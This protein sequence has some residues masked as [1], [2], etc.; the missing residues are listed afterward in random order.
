[1][2][3]KKMLLAGDTGGGPA[4]QGTVSVDPPSIAKALTGNVDVAVA[5]LLTSHKVFV[6]CQSDLE[7]GLVCIAAYCP[8]N[9][10][11]RIRICNWSS[12]AIDGASRTWAYQA[13]A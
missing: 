3:W 9:G 4:L 8:V 1:M 11:L 12:S 5:G 6:Q 7:S 2:S 10:T 13:Y